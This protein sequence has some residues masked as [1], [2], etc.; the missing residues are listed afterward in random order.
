MPKKV[1]I[2]AKVVATLVGGRP[3]EDTDNSKE[4]VTPQISGQQA[5][6]LG[7]THRVNCAVLIHEKPLRAKRRL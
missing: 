7:V 4:V 5:Q 3:T 1:P 6:P 2:S